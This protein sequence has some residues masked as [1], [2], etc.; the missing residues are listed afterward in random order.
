MSYDDDEPVNGGTNVSVLRRTANG[1]GEC[2]VAVAGNLDAPTS[3]RL[4]EQL[5]ALLEQ[6]CR[7]LVVDLRQTLVIEASGLRVLAA[8]LREL[9]EL[10]GALVL[11][12]PPGQAYELGRVR[13]LSELVATVDA[14]I[15]EVEAIS[16]LDGVVS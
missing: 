9:E 7:S 5:E 10:G 1:K 3:Q 11:R 4:H 2:W 14:A 6:G 15:D 13:R 12:T 8:A 16:R